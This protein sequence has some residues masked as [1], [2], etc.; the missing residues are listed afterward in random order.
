M[1]RNL[2]TAQQ[3]FA[4]AYLDVERQTRTQLRS[5]RVPSRDRDELAQIVVADLWRVW[6]KRYLAGRATPEDIGRYIRWTVRSAISH[7]GRSRDALRTKD[8]SGRLLQATL[9]AL[10]DDDTKATALAAVA[11]SHDHIATV[12]AL[13]DTLDWFDTLTPAKRQVAELLLSHRPAD[14]ARRLHLT[15]GRICQIQRDLHQEYHLFHGE[16]V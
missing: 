7:N 4:A 2:E 15:P 12:D 1:K 6:S 14:V 8:R 13:V 11:D 16:L 5:A 3:I 10:A 9:D